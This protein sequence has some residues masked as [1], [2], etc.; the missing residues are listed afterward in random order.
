ML[1]VQ[2]D[3]E[4]A[5]RYSNYPACKSNHDIDDLVRTHLNLVRKI[6]RGIFVRMST[7]MSF[8]DMV[9]TGTVGLIEAA[10]SFERRGVAKFSTFATQRIRGAIIDDLR[11]SATISRQALRDRRAFGT[12]EARLTGRLGRA[13]RD[14]E[15][16]A[17]L[18]IDL[19][20]YRRAAA[21]TRN[22]QCQSI[23]TAYSDNSPWF[24]DPAPSALEWLERDE[25]EKAA[26]KAI[27]GLPSREGLVLQMFFVEGMKLD[28]IGA[29]LGV[30]AARVSQL[31]KAA[32]E[33]VQ[34]RLTAAR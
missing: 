20:S 25:M 14:G 1:H 29:V 13:P 16:A 19:D 22:V 24:A 3:S 2:I 23:E 12:V 18:G 9:Q 26:I 28:N 31:K 10:T 21:A 27:A 17:A 6:A 7:A 8:E 15:M 32:L 30:T 11:Q 33:K 34:R 5:T 4:N